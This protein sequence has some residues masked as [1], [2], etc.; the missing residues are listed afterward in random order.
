MHDGM[1]YGRIQ[2]Q[3]QGHEPLKVRIPSIFKS[4]LLHLQWELPNKHF[5][6]TRAQYLHLIRPDF[7][8]LSY[9]LCHVALNLEQNVSCKNL[10]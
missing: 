9:F 6:L 10:I 7:S 8:Y 4:Y 1:P 5:F 3:G 2:G